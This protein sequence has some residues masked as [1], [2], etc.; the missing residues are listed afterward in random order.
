MKNLIKTITFSLLITTICNANNLDEYNNLF[1]EIGQKRV[2]IDEKMIDKLK[3]PFVMKKVFVDK[4]DNNSTSIEKKE[5]YILSGIFDKKA[6]INGI[7]H[8]IGNEI[9]NYKLLNIKRRSVIIGND[10]YKQELFI[11][12]NNV[13]KIKFSSK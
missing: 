9:G 10:H 11:R 1:N 6:K 8:E 12:K 5:T 2:G 13:S 4:K 7:W 3:N